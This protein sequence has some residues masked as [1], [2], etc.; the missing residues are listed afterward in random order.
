M[1]LKAKELGLPGES[2]AGADLNQDFVE[3]C[4]KEGLNVTRQDFRA[5]SYPNLHFDMI[6]ACGLLTYCVV[7]MQDGLKIF[8]ELD[9]ILKPGGLLIL[10]GTNPLLPDPENIFLHPCERFRRRGYQVLKATRPDAIWGGICQDLF[11]LRKL[12]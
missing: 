4:I 8:G 3:H 5:T 11:V 7:S 10:T 2:L 1:E 9:R 12:M 6:A